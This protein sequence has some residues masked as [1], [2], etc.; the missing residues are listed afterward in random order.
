MATLSVLNASRGGEQM[1][2]VAAAGGGD[3]F[4]NNGKTLFLVFNG[5]GSQCDVSFA[6]T[7]DPHA[8]EPT[9][10]S[11]ADAQAVPA[12]EDHVFGPFP[13]NKFGAS[14]SV[15]YNQ[16]TSVTVLPVAIG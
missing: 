11:V 4:P 14:V 5:G 7:T 6:L 15:T 1:S 16:V 10:S 13:T 3:D 9:Q 2:P 12:G 8:S